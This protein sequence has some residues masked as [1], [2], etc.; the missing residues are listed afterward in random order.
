MPSK[1]K[2]TNYYLPL[3][4]S[5]VVALTISLSIFDIQIC[6][7]NGCNIVGNFLNIDQ[8]VLNIL[9]VIFFT[10]LIIFSN[11]P[12]LINFILFYAFLFETFLIGYQVFILQT[13]CLYCLGIYSSLIILMI[14]RSKL[15]DVFACIITIVIAFN[16]VKFVPLNDTVTP[17]ESVLFYGSTSCEHCNQAK[18][19]LKEKN[20]NYQFKNIDDVENIYLL[21][22]LHIKTIP[23]LV[24]SSKNNK[25]VLIGFDEIKKYY[26]KSKQN[27]Q[28]NFNLLGNPSQT[29]PSQAGCKL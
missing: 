20:I 19:L 13:I 24:V 18:K 1:E 22:Q 10:S 9:G 16:I 8:I 3:F 4:M 17:K 23:T 28:M 29:V 11:K 25:Q 14:L 15:D 7:S 26:E 5:I 12:K 21:K 6:P 27:L 2:I